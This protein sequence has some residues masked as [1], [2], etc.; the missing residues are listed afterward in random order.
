MVTITGNWLCG[1]QFSIADINVAVLLERLWELGFENRFWANGKRPSIENYF[2]RIKQRDSFK[3]TI[4]N[5]PF[6]LKMI[7]NSQPPLYIG[8]AACTS[9]GIILGVV[10]FFKK[11]LH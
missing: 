8:A 1:E 3:K 6:H 10:Y 5:L 9:L 7:I 11:L 2:E 4:P